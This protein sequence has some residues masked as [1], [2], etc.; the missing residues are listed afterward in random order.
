MANELKIGALATLVGP[1]AVMGED[2]IRGAQLAIHEFGGQVSGR[3]IKLVT[4]GSNA[5]PD[6]AVEKLVNLLD[7]DRAE[8][9]I[10][11]LSGNEG[12]AI[13]DYAKTRPDKAF[14]NGV[15]GAQDITL[16]DP[17][18]NFF[19]F[20]TN[21]VQWMT[22]LG[23]YAYEVQGYRNVVTLAEDY[24]YPHGQVAGFMLEFCRAGGNV[25]NKYWVS[26]GTTDYSKVI[27]DLPT[28]L[29][30]IFVAL[31]GSDAV[32]FLQQYEQVGRLTPLIGGSITIDQ[33]VLGVK[34]SLAQ[35]LIGM[36]SSGPI[37]DSNPAPAW[38]SFVTS[39]RQLFPN[40]LPS[41][42]LFAYGYYVNMKGALLALQTV[43]GNLSDKHVGFM[44]ALSNVRFDSPTGSVR[45]DHNRNAI[46]SNFIT[47]INPDKNGKLFNQL[48]RVIAD[49][50]QT[51]GIPEQEYLAI[52][53]F[54]RD[55]PVCH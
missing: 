12:L 44:N 38:Q 15:A 23:R 41:P 30:A 17:A 20:S 10:G 46:A 47:Q 33:T 26:L 9:V 42:S 11:P 34:G 53:P 45:L 36:L 55:N 35:G 52:G 2:S 3:P 24:S 5:I 25:L 6:D 8:F 4:R 16:R 40:G 48:I 19:S 54:G 1:Y 43:N 14:I 32:N 50:D 49:V 37:A 21:G 22:G 13:R 28:G 51:L 18:P 7:I 27:A 29:D 39:Y 31:G